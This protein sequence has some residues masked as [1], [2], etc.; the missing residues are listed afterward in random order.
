MTQ[1]PRLAASA[2]LLALAG[3]FLAG[4]PPGTAA[5]TGGISGYVYSSASATG[6]AG[7]KVTAYAL[8]GTTPGCAEAGPFWKEVVSTTTGTTGAYWLSVPPGSYRIGVVPNNLARNSFGFRLNAPAT[9]A[10]VTG[11]VG[12]ADDVAA[13]AS[14]VDVKLAVPGS[15]QGV[16]ADMAIRPV[17]NVLVQAF[18][19][20]G[21]G[22]VDYMPSG[23]VPSA[24]TDS[25]GRYAIRGL[26]TGLSGLANQYMLDA[27]DTTGRHSEWTDRGL[28]SYISPGQTAPTAYMAESRRLVGT[29]LDG[30]GNALAGITVWPLGKAFALPMLTTDGNGHFVTSWFYQP[31]FGPQQPEINVYLMFMDPKGVYRT[32]YYSGQRYQGQAD[33]ITAPIGFGDVRITQVLQKGVSTIVGTAV[34]STAAGT[35]VNVMQQGA[36]GPDQWQ[37]QEAFGFAACDGSFTVTGVWPGDHTVFVGSVPVDITTTAGETADLGTVNVP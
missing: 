21:N 28:E 15:I 23:Y 6:L 16:V 7:A 20:A 14:A 27:V 33:A 10:N 8:P 29:V 1:L 2:G 18:A 13:P 5:P 37:L 32:T 19:G 36:G 25:N 12:W 4:S 26:P 11:W 9:S 24:R 34:G 30:P 22:N 31:E 35:M 3:L 17:A